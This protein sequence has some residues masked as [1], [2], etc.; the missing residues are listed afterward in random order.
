LH[1]LPNAASGALLSDVGIVIQLGGNKALAF[2]TEDQL[3]KTGQR[4]AQY[5]PSS[6]SKT[7]LPSERNRHL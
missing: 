4:T 3:V 7:H 5:R 1:L 2:S 6:N